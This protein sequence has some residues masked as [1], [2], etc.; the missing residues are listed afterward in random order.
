MRKD[1]LQDRFHERYSKPQDVKVKD[2]RDVEK[3]D[4]VREEEARKRDSCAKESL[5]ESMEVDEKRRS[6]ESGNAD[7]EKSLVE[8]TTRQPK[9]T[10][11]DAIHESSRTA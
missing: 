9:V 5:A 11:A 4:V 6:T 10:T 2:V 1:R 8:E 3:G 7:D